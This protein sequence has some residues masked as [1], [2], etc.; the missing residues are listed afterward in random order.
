MA[1]P[2]ASAADVLL[3]LA[4]PKLTLFRDASYVA[5]AT[6][7]IARHS[8]TH[9]IRSEWMARWLRQTYHKS[10]GKSVTE[11]A[12]RQ[13]R[14]TLE[15]KATDATSPVR[16]V[17]RRVATVDDEL[18]VDLVDQDWRCIQI[19]SSG[20]QILPGGPPFV[21]SQSAGPLPVPVQGVPAAGLD[22]LRDLLNVDSDD[23]WVLLVAWVLA[24]LRDKGPYPVLV[25]LGEHGSA[26]STITR[27][28]RALVDPSAISRRARPKTEQDLF[29]A[30]SHSHVLALENISRIPPWLSD[31]LCILSTGGGYGARK[32]RTDG[33]EHIFTAIRPLIIN[34]VTALPNRGDLADRSIVV[35]LEPIPG[36][37]R[38]TERQLEDQFRRDAPRILGALLSGLATGLQN[39]P[40]TT[41]PVLPRLADF[42]VWATACESTYWPTGTFI[43]AYTRS[44]DATAQSVVE[45]STVGRAIV[46]LLEE[47]SHWTGTMTD[48]LEVLD[49][50]AVDLDRRSSDWPGSAAGLGRQVDRLSPDLRSQ[51][52]DVIYSRSSQQRRVTITR[53]DTGTE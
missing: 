44:R 34:G 14:L 48:L 8:E 20:W 41:L 46:K 27:I 1:R 38:L 22:A 10:T 21:R 11:V 19:T 13:V 53:R 39:L 9:P 18:Y 43:Q 35:K 47:T 45:A 4:M 52:V 50:R 42:A 25:L 28:L 23:D 16:K 15:A 7:H 26:K 6:I 12:L 37:R 33:E 51:G 40:A 2:Q 36:R 31:V 5:Y 49:G 24:S 3:S 29:V 32:L 17:Y 30:T